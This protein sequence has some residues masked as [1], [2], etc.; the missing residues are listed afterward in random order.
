MNDSQYNLFTATELKNAGIKQ[1]ESHANEV[2]DNWS[3]SAYI[4]LLQFLSY[5]NA[6]MFQV[7][8]VRSF[9]SKFT[10]LPDPPSLR[11]WGAIILRAVKDGRVRH[12]GYEK[13]SNPKAH[14]TPAALWM[15][16]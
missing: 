12:A 13:T 11:A 16:I 7:E 10:D 15:K 2:I 1:A 14:N 9:A 5:E 6:N 8:Q 4:I 3:E